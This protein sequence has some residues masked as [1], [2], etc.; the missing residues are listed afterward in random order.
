MV[1]GPGLSQSLL[2][3]LLSR[4]IHFQTNYCGRSKLPPEGTPRRDTSSWLLHPDDSSELELPVRGRGASVYDRGCERFRCC[5]GLAS[6]RRRLRW[7]IG[8]EPR[9]SPPR[10]VFASTA[11][12]AGSG[13]GCDDKTS[14][15]RPRTSSGAGL[16]DVILQAVAAVLEKFSSFARRKHFFMDGF[17]GRPRAGGYRG[18]FRV[19]L[20]LRSVD[21]GG[22][23]DE[24]EFPQ[25]G[26]LH[27]GHD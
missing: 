5:V 20:S 11:L 16:L 26:F 19:S 9:L 2:S 24:D 25:L 7:Q 3:F 8:A 14:T 10:L 4:R 6:T 27:G 21:G 13:G 17:T 18:F 23:V 22:L 12:G 15:P 1:L